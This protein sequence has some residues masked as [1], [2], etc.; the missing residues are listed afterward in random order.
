MFTNN[1][2]SR[3]NEKQISIAEASRQLELFRRGIPFAKLENPCTPGNGI[4]IS[5]EAEIDEM[6]KFYAS[7]SANHSV[8]RFT[9]ASGAASRMFK[10]LFAVLDA[11]NEDKDPD[12]ILKAN[13]AVEAFVNNLHLYPFYHDL[14]QMLLTKGGG[15]GKRMEDRDY[16]TI[17]EALLLPSGL[18]YGSLPKALLKFHSYGKLYKTAF[19]EHFREAK[20]Y[21]KSRD[22]KINLHF[23]V[24][25]EHREL[26][27]ELASK[28]LHSATAPFNVSFSVQKSSTD[29]LA[30]DEYNN[31]F[32]DA[33]GNL[34]FRP[35]GHGALLDNLNELEEEIVF[36]GNIDN[37]PP[38]RAQPLRIRYKMYLGGF[39]LGKVRQVQE[40]LLR[41][42]RGDYSDSLRKSVV[43]FAE[44]I[45][46]LDAGRLRSLSK[47]EFNPAAYK[48]L[49]RPLRVCGM[50][51]NTGEPGGGPFWVSDAQGGISRQII[52]SSQV[53]MSDPAQK[54]V[55]ESSTHFNPVDLVCCIRDHTGKRFNLPEFRDSNMGF[56]ASK[57]QGGKV[58]KALEL[59]GLWNGS[60]AG[61][62]TWF[63]EVPA[64]TFTPVKTVFDLVRPDHRN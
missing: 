32:R 63:V 21:M 36:I 30:A 5:T 22:G 57:S 51:K 45:S 61:W 4:E 64:E 12:S 37:I 39:L 27:E 7:A 52:E 9:P 46:A 29:T 31:P 62:L 38:E 53:D 59:P 40:L 47:D 43:E 18:N 1:D 35:G 33:Q 42:E 6:V 25:P 60:M 49:H 11:L 3:L 56:I 19:E 17:L 54:K 48:L 41:I 20:P 13:P 24:S 34:V 44:G 10:D 23:T 15:I 26:F 14:N 58:L 50:V 16:K 28:V 8:T 2:L 55:F